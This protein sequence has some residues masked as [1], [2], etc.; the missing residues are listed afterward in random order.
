LLA[1]STRIAVLADKQVIA[2][3]KPNDVIAVRHP[4]IEQFFLGDRGQRALQALD[5]TVETR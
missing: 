1:L 2:Y 3:G 4:F 5:A